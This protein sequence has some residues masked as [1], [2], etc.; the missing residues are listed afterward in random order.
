MEVIDGDP[1]GV[2]TSFVQ[3]TVWN[4]APIITSVTASPSSGDEPFDRIII[5]NASDPASTND[6]LT[7]R[8]DCNGDG[9]FDVGPQIDPSTNCSFPDGTRTVNVVVEVN[10]G[11]GGITTGSTPVTVRNVAPTIRDVAADP[12]QLPPTG[13][14]SKI[15]V[16]ADDPA[17]TFDTLLYSF[18]CNND[19][20]FEV[21]QQTGISTDCSF[22]GG[23]PPTRTVKVKVEDGDQGE[24]TGQTIVIIGAAVDLSILPATSNSEVGAQLQLRLHVKAD[25]P[26]DTVQ[27]VIKFGWRM[28]FDSHTTSF[29]NKFS[30]VFCSPVGSGDGTITCTATNSTP[31]SGDFDVRLFNFTAV[32]IGPADVKFDAATDATLGAGSVLSKTLDA[33]VKVQGNVDVAMNIALE[34]VPAAGDNVRFEVKLFSSNAFNP[35]I[36]DTPWL[37]FSLPPD[38]VISGDLL[39]TPSGKNFSLRLPNVRT[40]VYDIT[41]VAKR[42]GGLK[43]TLINLMDDVSIDRRD[44][45]TN[46][47][48]LLEG[49]VADEPGEPTAIIDTLDMSV[50]AAAFGS[51]VGEERFDPRVNFDR[52]GGID[53]ADLVILCGTSWNRDA[54]N[55]PCANY[56]KLSPVIVPTSV[57]R[58]P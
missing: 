24:A 44:I 39:I 27:A 38:P 30:S 19:G 43:D 45:T 12:F 46:M 48:I 23:A 31:I 26:V 34:A 6:P 49:N 36:K 28:K 1:G 13:G 32:S 47:G 8:F 40:G 33:A 15:T 41:V 4:L 10:D 11:D 53:D 57:V 42:D 56:L 2:A 55:P 37:I 51:N 16:T 58:P 52:I 9:T 35:S 18:D 17:G 50:L 3:V 54:G 20:T 25:S 29:S 22:L 14:T 7:Y 5:V 21:F